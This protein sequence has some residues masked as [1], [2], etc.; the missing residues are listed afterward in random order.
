MI[1]S[2]GDPGFES[3]EVVE[4]F[5][6][7]EV[8][9]QI[10]EAHTHILE[11]AE[12][13]HSNQQQSFPPE[14]LGGKLKHFLSKWESITD[15]PW[16]LS[17]IRQGLE[18]EFM[19]E[20]S[21]QGSPPQIN[22]NSTQ[23]LAIN[24][25]IKRLLAIGCI[26]EVK[27][28]KS[29]SLQHFHCP[30]EKWGSQTSD[31]FEGLESISS[32]PSFQDGKF[33]NSKGLDTGR[34][35]DDKTR[36]ERSLSFSSSG[37]RSSEISCLPLGWQM[38]CLL[39]SSLWAGSCPTGV[40]KDHK[41]DSCSYPT[42]SGDSLCYVFRRPPDFWED[43]VRLPSKGKES[44]DT[45]TRAGVHNKYKEINLRAHSADRVSGPNSGLN[46][47]ES[48]SPR[49]KGFRPDRILSGNFINEISD[50]KIF[51]KSSREDEF[52]S[53][54]SSSCSDLLQ[55]NSGRHPPSNRQSQ[56]FQQKTD[57]VVGGQIRNTVVD[58][59]CTPVEWAS[60]S[61]AFPF[62]GHNNRCC[63]KRGMGGIMQQTQNSGQVDSR[64]GFSP[65]KHFRTKG[66]PFCSEIVCKSLSN[67]KCSREVQN[68]QHTCSSLHQSSRG[69][70]SMGLCN[71]AQELCKWCLLH[72]TIVSA[73][74]LPG[75]HNRDADQASR[76]FNDRTEWMISPHL[77]TEALSLLAVNPSIDL[78]ASRLHKHFPIFCSWKPDPYAW[79][80]DAFS[81]PWLQKGLYA[82]PPFCLVGKVL[83]KVIQDK[84]QNLVLVT[85]WWSSQPW[86]PLL[87]S[88]A[89]TQ[90]RFLKE[91]KRTLVFPHSQDLYPL[92]R[93]LKLAVWVVS[94]DKKMS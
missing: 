71:Q 11:R 21:H 18:L 30:Q 37:S 16:I 56:Q 39:C 9:T 46:P 2:I 51:S 12:L 91:T 53:P 78:F 45:V 7:P 87:K 33:S 86:F 29:F 64:G 48:V 10:Q 61:L 43:Q 69:T 44:N 67:D 82:F 34:G 8:P 77:L 92:W 62:S 20:P 38:L 80:I 4:F 54:C 19:V 74:H 3:R 22:M 6:T 83:A 90:P 13:S 81:F 63:Q 57:F 49:T 5:Q 1:L 55:G 84:S 89:I 32:F 14:K 70:K 52:L 66:S 31:Q 41:T 76:I 72:E 23:K 40:Y 25:E 15:D 75:I 35:L 36:F 28:T 94:G 42:E 60:S 58:S 47:D 65:H 73:E 88:L 93:Q 27:R 50:C 85:P 24:K 17:V 79:K 59:Q 26:K 68:R